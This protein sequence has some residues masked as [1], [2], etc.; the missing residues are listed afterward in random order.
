MKDLDTAIRENK[1]E[2]KQIIT[3]YIEELNNKNFKL[4]YSKIPDE[5]L[6]AAFTAL[7]LKNN[8]NPLIYMDIVPSCFAYELDIKEIVIPD[9]ITGIS[10]SAFK[11]CNN[12]TSIIIPNSVIIISVEAFEDC[13]NLKWISIPNSVEAIYDSA[14]N[15]CN[16][17]TDVYYEGSE[18]DW[19]NIETEIGNNLLLNANIHYNS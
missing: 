11:G 17:L 8:I 2:L 3:E 16:S 1:E 14:F 13:K 4:I 19:K 9:S 15:D 18:E 5:W 12:L 7:L 10:Y 6:T